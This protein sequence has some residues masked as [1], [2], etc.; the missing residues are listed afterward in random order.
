MVSVSQI[1]GAIFWNR[2]LY[3]STSQY[4]ES[5]KGIGN[6]VQKAPQCDSLTGDLRSENSSALP[7][8]VVVC[9]RNRRERLRRC[10]QALFGTD[11]AQEW[12]LVIVN[13]NSDDG[14]E[15]F[16]QSLPKKYKN[17][18]INTIVESR[19]GSGIAR[20]A[21]WRRARGDLIAFT[22]DDCYVS[23]DYISNVINAFSEN[24]SLSFL[25][26]RILLYDPNDLRMT[27]LEDDKYV[28]LKPRT[29]IAAGTVMSANMAFRKPV[30][31]RIGGFDEN[32][33]AGAG[34]ACEDIDAAASALW[35]GLSGAYDPRP[36]VYHHHGRKTE[37]EARDLLRIYD[38]GRGAYYAKYILRSDSRSEY[39]RGWMR[40]VKGEVRG[41]IR[42]IL[43]GQRPTMIRSLREICGGL[44]YVAARS[45]QCVVPRS[46]TSRVTARKAAL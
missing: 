27:V 11:S 35:E 38:K 26:G 13:N 24:E 12:E 21:G 16:L 1:P 29:F 31:D 17:I 18:S 43:R 10:V 20:N 42:A 7:L 41:A 45:R 5:S 9:T 6:G 30:L 8:S 44:Q 28:A 32:F 14:S 25:G 34:F 3:M 33:G 23:R 36:T 19:P 4:P 22:D 46:R 37:R 40:T 15:E 2:G 39:L